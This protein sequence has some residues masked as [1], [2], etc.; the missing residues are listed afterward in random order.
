[1]VA[2]ASMAALVALMREMVS[3]PAGVSPVF[4]D[5][6][7]QAAL[8]EHR[9]DVRYEQLEPVETLAPTGTFWND[10]YS[11]FR[12]WEASAILQDSAWA[13]LTPDSAELIVGRWHFAA[14]QNP[15]VYATGNVFDVYAAAADL[16][17]RWAAKLKL[18][19]D[20]TLASGR[21]VQ[22]R[23]KIENLR[24]LAAEYRGKAQA[25]TYEVERGD[26]GVF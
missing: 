7:V 26:C 11:R 15:P 22:R 20:F 5:D 25:V 12:Y 17:D 9:T 1:M 23:Q 24:A 16:L 19:A 18:D 4:S 14:S 8:D 21:G 3:D 6:Q 10:Y 2:R 13:T